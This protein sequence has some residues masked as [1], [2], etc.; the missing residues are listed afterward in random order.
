MQ[1]QHQQQLQQHQ[2]QQQQLKKYGYKIR[3]EMVKYIIIMHVHVN[4]HGQNQKE[5]ILKY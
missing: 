3:Q 4:P 1:Q 5:V 2:Q